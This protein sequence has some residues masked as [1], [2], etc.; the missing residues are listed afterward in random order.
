MQLLKVWNI[1][2]LALSLMGFVGAF[3]I[4]DIWL[5][6]DI[7]FAEIFT[8][9]FVVLLTVNIGHKIFFFAKPIHVSSFVFSTDALI[10]LYTSSILIYV[11][12]E[13]ILAVHN[14]MFSGFLVF[15]SHLLYLRL[16]RRFILVLGSIVIGF[17]GARFPVIYMIFPLLL[18]DRK[19][20]FMLS[21]ISVF[22]FVVGISR[23][24]DSLDLISLGSI[25]GVEWRDY[26][27]L[28]DDNLSLPHKGVFHFLTEIIILPIPGHSVFFD[29]WAIRMGSLPRLLAAELNLGVEGL[30]IGLVNEIQLLFGYK[31]LV[32][33]LLL[34]GG[35]IRVVEKSATENR[36]TALNLSLAY[37]TIY[38]LIGQTDVLLAFLYP[39][40]IFTFF[41]RSFAKS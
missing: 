5:Q 25:F 35:L 39:T 12:T 9:L 30:R 3:F 24:E 19:R 11:T 23:S 16:K 13:H 34:L 15:C 28:Y 6:N 33:A 20:L 36:V 14:I 38:F 21:L 29:T 1:S 26:F 18:M 41:A 22:I 32:L 17:S 37:S 7:N 31:V 2:L 8:H 40:L 10:F 27:L 4:K